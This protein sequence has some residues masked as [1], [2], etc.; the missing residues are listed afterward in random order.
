MSAPGPMI[1]QRAI[2]H[3]PILRAPASLNVHP[4]KSLPLNK[5]TGAPHFGAT[6]R[7]KVGALRPVR[8]Q[9]VPLGVLLVPTNRPPATL[10]LNSVSS[11]NPSSPLGERNSISPFLK[12]IF[13]NSAAWSV[14]PT[15]TTLRWP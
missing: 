13:F 7:L 4:V 10:P 2:L 5:V 12:S 1:H 6:F 14:S 3:R 11:L 8:G 15:I 9:D